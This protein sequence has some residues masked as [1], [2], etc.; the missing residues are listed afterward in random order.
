MSE[1]YSSPEICKAWGHHWVDTYFGSK[2]Q[3]CSLFILG[4]WQPNYF[5]ENDCDYIDWNVLD[6]ITASGESDAKQEAE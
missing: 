1:F 5:S 4:W 3:W 2:C 6:S